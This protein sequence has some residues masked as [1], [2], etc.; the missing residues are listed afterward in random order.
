MASIPNDLQLLLEE[1]SGL[2]LD[3]RAE[4]LIEYGEQFVGVPEDVAKPPYPEANKVPSCESDAYIF[5]RRNEDGTLQFYFAVLNP[6]GISAKAFAEILRET[7][8][9]QPL[10][11]VAAV[12]D[13]IVFTFFGAGISMGKGLGLRSMVQMV[14]ALAVQERARESALH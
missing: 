4:V 12:P 6:Q 2:D 11:Q 9:G 5:P 13:E 3:L 1:I 8:S 14:K 10:E 7:L